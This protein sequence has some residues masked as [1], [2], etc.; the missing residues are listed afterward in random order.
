[1]LKTLLEVLFWNGCRLRRH[2]L[3]DA[4]PALKSGSI[5]QHL[6]PGE[7]PEL[8][9]M[10]PIYEPVSNCLGRRVQPGLR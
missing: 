4:L 8:T 9:R 3:R 7:Q 2:V 10:S 1:M 5:Q 6:Q